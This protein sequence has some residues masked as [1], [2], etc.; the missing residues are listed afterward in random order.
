MA[1]EVGGKLSSMSW[2]PKRNFLNVKATA[3]KRT[4]KMK[5]RKGN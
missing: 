3:V 5:L 1:R 4:Q 2:H